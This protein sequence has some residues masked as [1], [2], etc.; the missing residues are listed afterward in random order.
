M[1]LIDELSQRMDVSASIGNL[2]ADV[3]GALTEMSGVSLPDLSSDFD[4]AGNLR[5]GID[6]DNISNSLD[7]VLA[8]IPELDTLPVAN[9]IIG[10]VQ[11]VIDLAEKL[12]AL[13]WPNTLQEFESG[14]QEQISSNGD[15]LSRLEELAG[16]LQGNASMDAVK[17]LVESLAE[18]TGT[19]LS[20]DQLKL[21]ELLP[22]V[23]TISK[24]IGHLMSMYHQLNEGNQ[25]A[26]FIG[27]QLDAD[28]IGAGVQQVTKQLQE[29]GT[30]PLRQMINDLDVNDDAAVAAVKQALQNAALPVVALRAAIAEGMGFGEATLV[31]LNP[32]TLKQAIKAASSDLGGLDLTPFTN[33][34]Q[35]V[36]G[37]L[38]PMFAV[39]FGNAPAETLDSWLTRLEGRVTELASGIDG[40]DIGSLTAPL[41]DGIEIVM[42]LPE[43]ITNALQSVKLSVKQGLDTIEDAVQA[44]PVENVANAIRTVLDPIADALE[45][46]GDLVG[47]IQSVLETA[48]G[49]LQGALDTA[50]DAVDTVKKAIED[51]FKQAQSYIDS[52]NLEQVI[53]EVSEQIQNFADLLNK[54]DMTPYFD[55]VVDALDTTT[56]VV[57]KVPFDMLPDSMEQDVVDLVK[58]VK[59]VDVTAFSNDIQSLLQIGPD[60]KFALRPDLE[61]ALEGIQ[62]KYDQ[63]LEVVRQADPAA[64]LSDIDNELSN[65]Q[66]KI[67]ELTPDVALEPV[68][69]AI[70]DVKGAVG[71]FNLNETLAPLNE[72]FDEL[73]EKI[74]EFKPSTML[75]P[76]EEKLTEVRSA[77]FGSFQLDTWQKQL[78]DL[79]EQTINLLDPLDPDQLQPALQ[80]L[81]DELKSQTNSLSQLELGY[82][83]GSI[84]NSL[85]G[86]RGARADAFQAVLEWLTSDAGTSLLT[87]L[88]GSASTAIDQAKNAVQ[89]VDPQ[90]IAVQLQPSIND[91]NSAISSLPDGEVKTELQ[92]CA[93][94]L[95]VEQ[96]IGGLAIHRQRYMQSLTDASAAFTELA[97]EGLSEVDLAVNQLRDAFNPLN[98]AREFFQQILGFIGIGGFEQGLQQVVN[99]TFA[100]ATPARLAG[101][102]T[103][104][105]TALKGRLTALLDGFLNPVL[106]A[107]ADLQA[108]Q[109]QLSLA[110]LMLELDEIHAAARQKVEALHPNNLL[111]EVVSAFNDSQTDVLNFDP[112]GPITEGLTSLQESSSRV[113]GKLSAEEIL[114]T[115]LEIYDDVLSLLESLDLGELLTPVLDVLDNLSQKVASGLDD[116]GTAFVRLQDAL[117]DQVGSTSVTGSVSAGT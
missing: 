88:A 55:A 14:L 86:G 116:T 23:Q 33:V 1:A 31:Q 13:D 74:D 2:E 45:F 68:Q 59:D 78:L 28:S 37:T 95:D 94:S 29:T 110:D 85:L 62:D 47:R 57:D 60:G 84:I 81:V 11:K 91:I 100:V 98:F 107:I 26:N 3:G 21:P 10:P 111:G 75:Q 9:D 7:A 104:L 27:K 36:A 106:D 8:Q 19:N 40:Y 80:S 16:F 54:A 105:L 97:N 41:T 61:A 43:E 79:R 71:S 39:D 6:L 22:A 44:I 92:Q 87:G 70:D 82:L 77:V 56:G 5:S 49:T 115:P 90:A 15:F 42:A 53:G 114:K 25:L 73:L 12:N 24:L 103:P 66:Q 102:F 63:L 93:R 72:G 76:L 101:V 83:V 108:L 64:L 17:S 18:L 32:D 109:D 46:I 30:V 67:Q 51:I 50:E 48:I 89:R 65:L 35:N 96:T 4:Q 58:P 34:V 113:L 52:L 20:A 112:L 38:Q 69:K 99:N 117:P